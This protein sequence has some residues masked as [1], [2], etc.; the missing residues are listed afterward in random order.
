MVCTVGSSG[1]VSRWTDMTVASAVSGRLESGVGVGL[2][3]GGATSGSSSSW[4]GTV[5]S[6]LRYSSSWTGRQS[7]AGSSG[8]VPFPGA[9]RTRTSRPGLVAE[10]GQFDSL[11]C[12]IL[13]AGALFCP[14]WLTGRECGL[15][16]S[17]SSH[18]GLSL[19][20]SRLYNCVSMSVVFDATGFGGCSFLGLRLSADGVFSLLF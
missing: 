8:V 5:S 16:W 2:D 19:S 4:S 12:C 15:T 7:E 17:T 6:A 10:G 1:S 14:V 13:E 11:A 9:S 18:A 3:V 20:R